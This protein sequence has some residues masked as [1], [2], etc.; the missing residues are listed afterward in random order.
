MMGKSLASILILGMVLMSGIAMGTAEIVMSGSGNGLVLYESTSNILQHNGIQGETTRGSGISGRGNITY[1]ASN[2]VGM[3]GIQGDLGVALDG[4]RVAMYDYGRSYGEGNVS[5]GRE[6]CVFEQPDDP[7]C[8][9]C[10]LLESNFAAT[11]TSGGVA[12]SSIKVTPVVPQ[13][14]I[15]HDMSM[16]GNGG[17][18]AG[19]VVGGYMGR[20]KDVTD[21]TGIM[22]S[23]MMRGRP[24]SFDRS[25]YLTAADHDS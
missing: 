25:V 11:L 6:V 17:V 19:V 1:T 13:A 5:G 16:R 10:A 2:L 18:S 8:E 24:L 21:I 7:E 22:D 15:D 12:E 23:I 20:D 3:D 14:T 9:Y 4:G